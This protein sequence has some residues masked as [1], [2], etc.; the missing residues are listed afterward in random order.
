MYVPGYLQGSENGWVVTIGWT[1]HLRRKSVLFSKG[2]FFVCHFIRH[3][4]LSISTPVLHH[5]HYY[6]L[7]VPSKDLDFQRHMSWSFNGQWIEVRGGCSCWWYWWNY[8]LSLFKLSFHKSTWTFALLIYWI[9]NYLCN[10]CIS[11]L[12]LWVLI[13]IILRCTRYN[14]VW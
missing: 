7:I 10:R 11:Q 1:T 2:H 6:Y 9:F 12:K 13:L 3:D 8:W 5:S 4:K 14:I